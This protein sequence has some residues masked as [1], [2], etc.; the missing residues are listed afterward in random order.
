MEV[1]GELCAPGCFTPREV[2]SGTRWIGGWA[3]PVAVTDME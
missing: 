2:M 1:S 3:G